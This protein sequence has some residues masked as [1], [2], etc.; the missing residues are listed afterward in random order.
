MGILLR[1]E[2]EFRKEVMRPLELEEKFGTRGIFCG[3]ANWGAARCA[4]TKTFVLA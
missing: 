3:W 1:K 4:P 2:K